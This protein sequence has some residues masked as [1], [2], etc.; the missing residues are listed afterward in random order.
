[1][2]ELLMARPIELTLAQVEPAPTRPASPIAVAAAEPRFD[3]GLDFAL[4]E[5]GAGDLPRSDEF[6]SPDT[7]AAWDRAALE[8]LRTLDHCERLFNRVGLGRLVVCPGHAAGFI[9]HLG[10][11]VDLPV[12]PFELGRHVDLDAVPALADPAEQARYLC[13]IGAALRPE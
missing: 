2:G 12:Q 9:T 7:T 6:G 10:G 11:L 13:A 5:P 1:M 8:I 4:P 3:G